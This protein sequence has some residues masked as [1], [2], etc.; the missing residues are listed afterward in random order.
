MLVVIDLE[1]MVSSHGLGLPVGGIVTLPAPRFVGST[2]SIG[3]HRA[4]ESIGSSLTTPVKA[5]PNPAIRL[6][7]EKTV[8]RFIPRGFLIL[9]AMVTLIVPAARGDQFSSVNLGVAGPGSGNLDLTVFNTGPTTAMASNSKTTFNGNFG[10]ANGASTNFS[11]G[12]TITGNLYADPGSSVQNNINQQF[13]INGVVVP[14]SLSAAVTAVQNASIAAAALTANETLGSIGGSAMTL[15]TSGGYTNSLGG[16]TEVISLTGIDI[17]NPSNNLTL[18][19]GA[20]DYFIINVGSG[21]V[22]VSDGAILATGGILASHILFNLEGTNNSVNLTNGTSSLV[23]TYLAVGVGDSINLT[24]GTV[25]GAVIGY[26]IHTSSGPTVI[27]DEFSAL[28]TAGPFA[29][30]EPASVVMIV[31]GGGMAAG[32]A[33]YRRRRAS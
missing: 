23:G 20:N 7:L 33:A 30:P 27:N 16:L 28:P 19:G 25:D 12:G 24:P 1:T 11:G 21:G 32:F 10:L 2:R 8:N 3:F 9:T 6:R 17:T 15:S 22:T 4:T 26:Q 14:Q 13:T 29:V 5:F 18:S 31:L